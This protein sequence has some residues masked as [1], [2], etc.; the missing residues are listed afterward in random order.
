[1]EARRC[2][3]KHTS[4]RARER[5]VVSRNLSHTEA[6]VLRTASAVIKLCLGRVPKPFANPQ[7]KR[8]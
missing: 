8:G 7:V 5:G 2:S 6:T 4:E 1:M 3:K